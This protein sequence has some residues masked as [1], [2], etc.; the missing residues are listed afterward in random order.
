VRVRGVIFDLW[1]TL[2]E[3]PHAAAERLVDRLAKVAPHDPAEFRRLLVSSY[4]A[5]QTGP[6]RDVYLGLGIPPIHVDAAIVEHHA[7][8]REALRLRAG[9]AAT[10]AQL[11]A[12]GLM[13]GVITVCSEEVP[14]VWR[15]TE[16]FGLFDAETFS[17]TCG[18]MK[19]E[20]EIYRRTASALGVPVESCLFVGDG[21]NDE[22]DGAARVGMTPVLFAP[23]R[24]RWPNL[25][26]WTGHRVSTMEEVLELC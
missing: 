4:R 20:P 2:V 13:I 26:Q 10:I 7:I 11:R 16:L 6:L 9:A 12:D 23:G 14:A 24:P 15:E 3:W 19:P 5:S 18:L 21:A 1:D 8:A 22:L 17:S 25:Q